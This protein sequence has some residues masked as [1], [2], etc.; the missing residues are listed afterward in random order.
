MSDPI[1]PQPENPNPTAGPV[2][3]PP[4]APAPNFPPAGAVPPAPPAPAYGSAPAGAVPPPPGYAPAGTVP[5]PPGYGPAGAVPPPPPAKKKGNGLAIASLVLGIIGTIFSF[6]PGAALGIV[7][8]ILALIFGIVTLVRKPAQRGVPLT[9][10]ILGGVALLFGIVFA[11]VYGTHTTAPTAADAPA[12]AAAT[13]AA[14]PSQTPA[15]KPVPS[16]APDNPNAAYDKLYGTFAP[17]NQTGTGDSV[18]ALPAGVKAGIVTASHQGSSNFALN[19]LDASNQPTGD[20]LVNTIGNYSGVTAYGMN[21][22][23][24]GV[25]LQVKADGAWN[26][27]ISPIGAAPDIAV[28]GNGSGDQVYKYGGASGNWAFTNQGQG[29]FAVIQYGGAMPNLA[30]NTI[31]AYSG[32]VPMFAGP[33]V[34]VVKSDGAWTVAPG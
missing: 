31:G 6:T 34:V 22:L 1:Q 21:A 14:Q 7:L 13:P 8:G 33:T 15:A 26:I 9:G 3:P 25:N 27:T 28:P 30:V 12:T 32:T 19:V 29:N 18:I 4:P 2:P 5:P 10:T 24:T 20:L 11:S 17:I 16:K 23:G